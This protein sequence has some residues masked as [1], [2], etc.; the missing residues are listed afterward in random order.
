ML[1]AKAAAGFSALLLVAAC[2]AETEQVGEFKNDWIGNEIKVEAL[3]DPEIPGVLC[4]FSHFDRGF[5]D[6]VGKGDWF[7]DPSNT[8]IDCLRVGPIDIAQARAGQ[9]GEEVFSQRHS[10]FFK[11]VAV[12][13]IFDEENNVLIYVSHS[14]EIVEGSAKM[15]L[16]TVALLPEDLGGRTVAGPP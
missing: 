1:N 7:E 10:L 12:R 14:R 16:S 8:S 2:G 15:S 5:W 11:N 13:R 4:H 3:H 9:A 6:R